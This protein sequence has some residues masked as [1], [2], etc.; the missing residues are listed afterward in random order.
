MGVV[1]LARVVL[2]ASPLRSHGRGAC[3][4]PGLG[5]GLGAVVFDCC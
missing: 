3:G 4:V 5:A 1:L 2:L